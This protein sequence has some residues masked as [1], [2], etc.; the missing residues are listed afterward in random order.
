[1]ID[2]RMQQFFEHM[3]HSHQ[4]EKNYE[5]LAPLSKKE[6]QE[7]DRINMQA[8]KGQSMMEQAEAKRKL[9]W[10]KIERKTGIY[11]RSMSIDGGMILVD[12]EKRNC[13]TK[14]EQIPGFCDGDCENCSLEIEDSEV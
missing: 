1:M 13:K 14:G 9:F 2:E 11:D 6:A 10:G 8:A 3:S 12:Q 7:W 4:E 5:P